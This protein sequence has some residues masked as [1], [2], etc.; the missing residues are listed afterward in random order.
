MD[1]HHDLMTPR[2]EEMG[3]NEGMPE[4]VKCATF[5]ADAPTGRVLRIS[6][7]LWRDTCAE[8]DSLAALVTDLRR[9]LEKIAEQCRPETQGNTSEGLLAQAC[10]LSLETADCALSLPL[11]AAAEQVKDWREK[12]ERLYDWATKWE[13]YVKAP[14]WGDSKERESFVEADTNLR[15]YARELRA[16][17]GGK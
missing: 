3:D 14:S 16:A 8:R 9:A 13:D 15:R 5:K 17:R 10:V 11:P 7:D 1:I 2:E 6:A 4:L 12:A